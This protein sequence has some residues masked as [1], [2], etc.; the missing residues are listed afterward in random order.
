MKFG[1]VISGDG[2]CYGARN[3]RVCHSIF[4]SVF[5]SGHLFSLFCQVGKPLSHMST[6]SSLFGNQT[7]QVKLEQ[8]FSNSTEMLKNPSSSSTLSNNSSPARVLRP[9]TGGHI[10]VGPATAA[11]LS[12][13]VGPFR[14][15][16]GPLP[17]HSSSSS[18]ML[19]L[20]NDSS[21]FVPHSQQHFSSINCTLPAFSATDVSCSG[22]AS[23]G[24]IVN[25]SPNTSPSV[26]LHSVMTSALSTVATTT[27]SAPRLSELAPSQPS[28]PLIHS[29]GGAFHLPA[30]ALSAGSLVVRQSQKPLGMSHNS[31]GTVVSNPSGSKCSSSVVSVTHGLGVYENSYCWLVRLV[32]HGNEMNNRSHSCNSRI[33]I[34]RCLCNHHN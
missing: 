15:P 5:S 4:Q 18:K 28:F 17:M 8:A 20:N 10:P 2:L 24:L 16:L 27:S 26:P 31:V 19:V 14:Y 3:A 29:T 33:S 12:A 34:F 25:T 6:T 22:P 32:F 21:A 9:S 1:C 30:S 23:G 11:A 13:S 7:N